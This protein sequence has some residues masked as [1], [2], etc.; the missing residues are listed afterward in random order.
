MQ[1]MSALPNSNLTLSSLV[2]QYAKIIKH[3]AINVEKIILCIKE[4]KMNK[5]ADYEQNGPIYLGSD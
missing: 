5:R 2:T 3:K 4:R 1:C